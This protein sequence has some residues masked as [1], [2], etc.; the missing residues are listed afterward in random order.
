VGLL[1]CASTFR[2][3]AEIEVAVWEENASFAVL[4][5]KVA[6]KS[7]MSPPEQPHVPPTSLDDQLFDFASRDE[8]CERQSQDDDFRLSNRARSSGV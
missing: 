8:N 1:D 7:K 2:S 6:A 4:I 5:A 3:L